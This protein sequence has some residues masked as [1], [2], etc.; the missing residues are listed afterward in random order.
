REL[1]V[2]LRLKHQTIV[3]LLGFAY[4]NSSSKFPALVSQWMPSGTLSVYLKE[5]TI[6]T[7]F[8]K[9][10]GVAAGL[11]YLQSMNVVHGD[12]HPG[13]VLID[14]SGNPCLAD[15]GLATIEGEAD[16]QLNPTTV[17]CNFDSRW[18]APEVLG[19]ECNPQKPTF[20]SDVY[21]FG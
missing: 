10:K 1:K 6:I 11:D 5:T 2:W 7:A 20:S 19:L 8:A 21:S 3:P 17:E 14:G 15:F 4:V 16:L 9:V 13:N 18:R 12:L